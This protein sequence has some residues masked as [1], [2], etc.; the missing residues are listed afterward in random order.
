M[1]I[2]TYM[3]GLSRQVNNV[4]FDDLGCNRTDTICYAELDLRDLQQRQTRPTTEANETYNRGKRD[5]RQR[6]KR[7]TTE[8]EET[9][10]RGKRDLQQTPSAIR[11][12]D[13]TFDSSFSTRLML[14]TMQKCEGY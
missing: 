1:Y 8:A 12:F 7:P 10:S 2:Y 6:Q 3:Y 4:E 5:L 9:Y 14:Q 11:N 13:L